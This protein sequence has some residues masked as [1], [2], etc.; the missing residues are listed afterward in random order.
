MSTT[1]ADRVLWAIVAVYATFSVLKATSLAVGMGPFVPAVSILLPLVF[2]MIHGI[3]RLGWKTLLVFF[4]ITFVV[5]WSY[6]SLSIA[7]GFPFGSYHYSDRL[8][9]KLGQVPLLIM[10]AYFAVCYLCWHLAH[11]VLDKFDRQPDGLQRFAVPVLASFIMVMWDMSMDPARSTLHEA[12]IW[13]DGGAYFGVP[14]ENF[15]GWFLC[16]YTVFQ[17]LRSVPERRRQGGRTRRGCRRAAGVVARSDGAV[18]RPAPRVRGRCLF[19]GGRHGRGCEFA[20]VE[21]PRHVRVAGARFNLQ[22]V[23][24][25][26]L[27][28]CEGADFLDAPI[29]RRTP[30]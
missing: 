22:H 20:G 23:V 1:V 29:G 11:I 18:R 6:E 5:S 3:P 14:F 26:V 13:H 16:V 15:M 17:I 28:L 4:G 7:T 25:H 10:P 27:E 24:C 21:H 2:A 12:W 8:G 9:P 30:N 19:R